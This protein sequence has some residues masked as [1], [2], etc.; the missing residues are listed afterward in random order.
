MT[1]ILFWIALLILVVLAVR[2][3]LRAMRPPPGEGRQP[4][5]SGEIE[6]VVPCEQTASCI[7]VPTTSDFRP[8][9]R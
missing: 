9:S 5:Q 3:K 4:G 2:S 6:T 8:S 1:R 7:A